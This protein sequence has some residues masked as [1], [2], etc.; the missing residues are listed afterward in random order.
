MVAKPDS[1]SSDAFKSAKW[2]E[3]TAGRDFAASDVPAL[4]LLCQWYAVVERCMEDMDMGGE[5]PQV[6]YSN[7]MGDVRALPQ[8]STMKQASAEIRQLNR[9]LGICDEAR[10]A[11]AGKRE[12][13]LNIVQFNRIRKARAAGA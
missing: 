8:L 7:D 11:Q 1:V 5:L 12:T 6:A 2:D 9:Q 3:L 4:T 13:R 10:P